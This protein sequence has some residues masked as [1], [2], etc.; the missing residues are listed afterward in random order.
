MKEV[1]LNIGSIVEVENPGNE[2]KSYL[3]IGRR[4]INP[5][6]MKAWDYISVEYLTG[7]VRT[8]KPN[9]EFGGD[10]FF[11]FNHPDIDKITYDGALK[12]PILENSEDGNEGVQND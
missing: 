7:L 6:S 8:F 1:L 4:A 5:S 3:I 2:R 9:N 12:N 10:D 11:Y